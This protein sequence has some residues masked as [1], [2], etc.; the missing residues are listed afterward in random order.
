MGLL[1]QQ[2][3]LKWVRDNIQGNVK[4][5]HTLGISTGVDPGSRKRDGTRQKRGK[6]HCQKRRTQNTYGKLTYTAKK[7]GHMPPF[8]T[9]GSANIKIIIVC[10]M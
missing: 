2:L 9:P 1:D 3:A 8:A 4:P 6:F 7:G 5:L 10:L